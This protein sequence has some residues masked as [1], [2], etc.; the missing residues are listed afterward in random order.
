MKTSPSWKFWPRIGFLVDQVALGGGREWRHLD[1]GAGAGGGGQL[2]VDL[3]ALVAKVEVDASLAR[4]GRCHFF[5]SG[6]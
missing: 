5:T 6:V 4:I 1:G 3:L 2:V